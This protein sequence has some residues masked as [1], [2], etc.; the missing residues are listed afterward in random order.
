MNLH[1]VLK[2]GEELSSQKYEN[3]RTVQYKNIKAILPNITS[4]DVMATCE[5][6]YEYPYD[7][8]PVVMEDFVNK[9]LDETHKDISEHDI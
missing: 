1:R 9:N 8:Y 5:V 3:D 4:P 2:K 6:R 7:S